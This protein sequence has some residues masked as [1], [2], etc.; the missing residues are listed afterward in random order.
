MPKSKE[1]SNVVKK[2]IRE[3]VSIL[4]LKYGFPEKEA[5]QSLGITDHPPDIKYTLESCASICSEFPLIDNHFKKC[6]EGYGLINSSPIK[7]AI[8]EEI[9]KTIFSSLGITI[10]SQS[11]GGHA[12]GMDMD[13]SIGRISNKTSKYSNNRINFDISSYRLTGVC[14]ERHFGTPTKFTQ[15]I[16]KRKNFDYYSVLVRDE[17]LHET[18]HYDWLLIP[19]NYLILDPYSYTWEP[20]IG[21]RGKNKDAQ[22]GWKTNEINGCRMEITFSTSSQLWIH[23][24]MSEEIKNFIV[25]GATIENKP[26]YNYMDL[27]DKL[28]QITIK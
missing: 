27:V 13:C 28:N 18:I 14:S 8:W 25:A 12:P 24:T 2:K 20:A 16:N 4:S 10:Y 1:M 17:S 22:V 21:K 15:E 7:E 19:S 6:V 11:K 3:C 23:V 26:K 5:M 9:N